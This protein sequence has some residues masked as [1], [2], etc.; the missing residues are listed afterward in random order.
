MTWLS[1][2]SERVTGTL[3]LADLGANVIK[4][5]DTST[6]GDVGRYVPPCQAGQDSLFLRN[7]LREIDYEES[8]VARPRSEAVFGGIGVAR[9]GDLNP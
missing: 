3:R 9:L 8:E 2:S 7:V 5:E 4:I 6:G 1:S